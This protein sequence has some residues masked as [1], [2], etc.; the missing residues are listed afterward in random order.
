MSFDEEY[1]DPHGECAHEINRLK[2]ELKA[3][4]EVLKQVMPLVQAI[5]Q[6]ERVNGTAAAIVSEDE[7]RNMANIIENWAKHHSA[8]RIISGQK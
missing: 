2:E 1:I 6:W 8:R 5:A 7:C 4:R 3:A